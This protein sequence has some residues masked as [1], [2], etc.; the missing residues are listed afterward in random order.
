MISIAYKT[1]SSYINLTVLFFF[2]ITTYA[3]FALQLFKGKWREYNPTSELNSFRDI[4]SSWVSVFNI[5]TNDDWVGVMVMGTTYTEKGSSLLYSVSM[6]FLI[7]Y[8][9][10]GLLLAITLNGFSSYLTEIE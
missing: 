1:L 7:N 6:I 8:F 3:V 2:L 9:M 4:F 10:Y 5:S